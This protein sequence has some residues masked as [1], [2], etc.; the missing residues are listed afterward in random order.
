MYQ[1][2][3]KI[4]KL[5]DHIFT[6][7]LLIFLLAFIFVPFHYLALY[8][9]WVIRV[10]FII[11]PIWLVLEIYIF[12]KGTPERKWGQKKVD[13]RKLF[14]MKRK[15]FFSILQWA[16]LI[17]ILIV[18]LNLRSGNIGGAEC[19]DSIQ[20]NQNANLKIKYFYSPFCPS[21]WRSEPILNEVVNN[22]GNLFSIEKYDIRYC[23]KVTEEYK[24]YQVPSYVFIPQNESKESVNY[25]F[26][27]KDKFEEILFDLV[28]G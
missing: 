18:L 9:I 22:Q 1:T 25:G 5:F 6:A 27:P 26:I 4:K 13:T 14:G 20:G 23:T 24:I 8:G 17:I 3:K 11:F 15:T 21:C 19:P 10:S 2:I 7:I 12:M 28:G 16:G